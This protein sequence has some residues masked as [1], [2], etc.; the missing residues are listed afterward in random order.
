MEAAKTLGVDITSLCDGKGTCGK[1]K[2]KVQKGVEGLTHPT[3]KEL[4]H[5]SEE[6]LTQSFRLACQTPLT[7]PM[8]IYV[9]E[10]SRVGKQRLQT[11]GLEVPVKPN[12][13]VKKYFIEMPPP[14][15]HDPRADEDRLIDAL[16]KEHD[17]TSLTIDYETAKSLPITLRKANWKVTAV[18]FKKR[19]IIV[20]SFYRPPPISRWNG[21]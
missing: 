14:T 2:V 15:L 4:K 1:C 3:E 10:R 19:I 11:D 7:L 16:R 5:L 8:V 6:E 9:P 18:T 21:F 12:P 13:L 17:L 20:F